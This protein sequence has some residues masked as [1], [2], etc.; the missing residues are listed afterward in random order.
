M[1]HPIRL[2]AIDIDGTL[3]NSQ[4][5]I[6]DR[7]L[8]TLRRAHGTGIEIILVTGRRHSFALPIAESI[9]FPLWLISSNGAVTK[10][11]AGEFFHSDFLPA[12]TA[13]KLLAWM[14][15]FRSNAVITFDREDRGA[16]VIEGHAGF[17]GSI[18][19]WMEKNADFI[20][21]IA[22]LENSLVSD[23]IQ[24]MFCG[25]VARMRAAE[26]RLAAS[27]MEHEITVLKTEYEKRDLSIIDV[28]NYGCSKGHAVE[29]WANRRGIRP[30]QVMAIGDNYNDVEMLEFAGTPVIMANACAELLRAGYNVTRS[31]DES[32]V[33][34]AIEEFAFR[35][36]E[37]A[38][39]G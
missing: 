5:Q 4:F 18:S 37:S 30:E 35:S 7:N 28:L 21:E 10:S 2:V 23:P 29:R 32:G 27:A 38:I 36:A 3:L 14:N 17:Q 39:S 19:R 1:T 25:P 13:R 31:N 34:A 11:A 26:A 8:A 16:L 6:S 22:P 9:G 20:A 24:A 15:D 33:A 12:V